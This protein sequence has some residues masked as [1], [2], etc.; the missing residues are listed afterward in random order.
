MIEIEGILL[1]KNRYLQFKLYQEDFDKVD[2]VF[3]VLL[4]FLFVY[5][6]YIC[7]DIIRILLICIDEKIIVFRENYVI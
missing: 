7:R 5:E 3:N 2:Y 6:I 4:I 1:F